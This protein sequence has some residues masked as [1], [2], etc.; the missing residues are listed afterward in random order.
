MNL[1]PNGR[2]EVLD[3]GRTTCQAK[4]TIKVAAP[5]RGAKGQAVHDYLQQHPEA[6]VKTVVEAIKAQGLEV[7]VPLVGSFKYGGRKM[8]KKSRAGIAPRA[9][10][11][12]VLTDLSTDQL[13]QAKAFAD[14]LGGLSQARRALDLLEQLRQLG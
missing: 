13:L 9:M 4:K 3:K 11:E 5:A 8:K 7:S 12:P 2:D 1:N 10:R 14:S 6:S